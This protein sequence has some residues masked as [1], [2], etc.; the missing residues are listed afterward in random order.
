MLRV[1]SNSYN[2][3]RTVAAHVAVLPNSGEKRKASAYPRLTAGPEAAQQTSAW[4][5]TPRALTQRCWVGGGP[6]VGMVCEAM[7][8]EDNP[9]LPA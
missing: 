8:M 6:C 9:A 5:L 3:N 1:Q 7:Q 2:S 4:R